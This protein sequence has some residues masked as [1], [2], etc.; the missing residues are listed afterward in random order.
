MAAMA[1]NQTGGDGKP[2]EKTTAVSLI[3]LFVVIAL[4]LLLVVVV[5]AAIITGQR[6]RQNPSLDS[7]RKGASAAYTNPLYGTAHTTPGN[8]HGDDFDPTYAEI[9]SLPEDEQAC[10]REKRSIVNPVYASTISIIISSSVPHC[11]TAGREVAGKFD[12]NSCAVTARGV[13]S[14]SPPR[15]VQFG[16][17]PPTIVKTRVATANPTYSAGAATSTAGEPLYADV[18]CVLGSAQMR[19]GAEEDTSIV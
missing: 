1:A 8:V 6:T 17:G 7:G 11:L 3:V 9:P 10:A 18:A 13:P 14:H 4:F 5:M 19:G 15:S 2:A 16:V 12:E